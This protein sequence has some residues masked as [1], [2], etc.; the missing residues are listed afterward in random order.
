MSEPAEVVDGVLR[1]FNAEARRCIMARWR[2]N[3][4]GNFLR[5]RYENA[6]RYKKKSHLI[7]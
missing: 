5:E 2:G 3:K 7:H 4:R 6:R 1:Q